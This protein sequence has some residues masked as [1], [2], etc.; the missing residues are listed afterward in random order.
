M[1]DIF[2]IHSSVDGHLGCFPVLTNVNST[3]MNIEMRVSFPVMFFSGYMPRSGIAGPYDSSIFSFLRNLQTA[4]HGDCTNLNSHQQYRMVPFSVH[5]L[6]YFLFVDIYLFI[7]NW[8][9]IDLQYCIDFYQTSTGISHRFTHVPSHLNI[10]PPSFP[11]P[12][13][14]VVMELWFKFRVIQ[15]LPIGC[16]LFCIW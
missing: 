2:F 16:R 8:R 6:Q 4:L 1:Y 12:P 13:L 11:I 3:K 14:V 7:F 15:Q 10:L 9:I 5:P